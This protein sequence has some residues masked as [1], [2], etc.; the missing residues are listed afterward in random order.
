MIRISGTG[1]PS[2]H[3]NKIGLTRP[4]LSSSNIFMAYSSSDGVCQKQLFDL[5]IDTR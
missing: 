3:N 5:D 4:A 1:T 2:A